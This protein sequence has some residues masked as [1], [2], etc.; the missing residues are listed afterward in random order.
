M[1]I[2]T[3]AIVSVQQVQP[4]EDIGIYILHGMAVPGG[5]ELV[6]NKMVHRIHAT[7]IIDEDLV[8]ADLGRIPAIQALDELQI[9]DGDQLVIIF[10]ARLKDPRNGHWPH[11]GAF[12]P[13]G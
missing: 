5:R 2:R 4:V 3:M 9:A 1:M 12:R 11:P 8:A 10:D 13:A 6:K 7:V